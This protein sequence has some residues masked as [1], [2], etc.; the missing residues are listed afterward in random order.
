[1]PAPESYNLD[2]RRKEY[3][4]ILN[5]INQRKQFH[6]SE[7]KKATGLNNQSCTYYLKLLANIFYIE[8]AGWGKWRRIKYPCRLG[9]YYVF[10]LELCSPRLQWK[11]WFIKNDIIYE[12]DEDAQM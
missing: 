3:E 4:T 1:M 10:C 9:K 11:D 12:E 2:R 7:I 8:K 6:M 5:F